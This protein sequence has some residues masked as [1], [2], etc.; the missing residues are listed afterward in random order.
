MKKFLFLILFI[1]ISTT[2]TLMA[3][4]AYVAKAANA[5]TKET[6]LRLR[7]ESGIPSEQLVK[8]YPVFEDFYTEIQSNIAEM[9]NSG[10]NTAEEITRAWGNLSVKRDERLIKIFSEAEIAKWQK[11]EPSLRLQRI[12]E[13]Q[14]Y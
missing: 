6:L 8:V 10:N 13:E 12:R 14:K 1:L 9:R 4:P 3:Q 2:G 7:D 5:L 11:I